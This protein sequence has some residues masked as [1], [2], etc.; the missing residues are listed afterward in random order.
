MNEAQKQLVRERAGDLFEYC[1]LPRGFDVLPF[2]ID[3]IIDVLVMNA[4]E[5]VELRMVETPHSGGWIARFRMRV[6]LGA[7]MAGRRYKRDSAKCEKNYARLHPA[8]LREFNRFRFVVDVQT[9]AI[10]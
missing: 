4:P 8:Y 6:R 5:R 7:P 1:R 9:V 2:Q 10:Q 3:H